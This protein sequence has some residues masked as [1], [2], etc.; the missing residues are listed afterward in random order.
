MVTTKRL[1]FHTLIVGLGLV[2]S[3]TISSSN[4]V[5]QGAPSYP[6][7]VASAGAKYL[8][9]QANKPFFINGE[10]AWSLITQP[11]REDATLFLDNRQQKGY[12]VFL[13]M[14]INHE[15]TQ[16]AP[17]NF[18]GNQPFTTAGNFS[19]PNEA[20]FQHAD[21]VINAAAARGQ[22]IMLA[23]IYIGW[24]CSSQGWCAEI[25]NQSLA[26]MR[27][28][29]QYVGNRYKN[30]P[31]IIWLIGGDA[32]AVAHGIGDKVSEF[33]AGL[34]ETDPNHIMTVHNGRGQSG[35]S[36]WPNASWLTLN[37][38]YTDNFTFPQA[39]TEYNR[40]PAKPAFLIESY[41]ERE[42]GSTS[43]SLRSQAYWVVLAGALGGHVFGN[44]PVTTFSFGLGACGD[45]NWK[46]YLDSDGATTVGHVGKL[47][48]S[49]AFHLLVPDLNHTVMTAGFQ[50]GTTYAN[51]ARTSDGSTVIA[52][53]PTSRAVT[54]D[55]TKVAGTTARTWWYN[56]RTG[57]STAGGDFPTTGTRNFTPPDGNDW[58]LVL[59][60]AALNL[61]APGTQ[62]TTPPA[63]AAP[64]NVRIVG[65]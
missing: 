9:D 29:G 45:P 47:F 49:R 14:L 3:L 22:V 21:W 62:G 38:V 53:I 54:F 13:V 20:Y 48:N 55:M 36:V 39:A 12:N 37:S 15:F 41:Y 32:D 56:P 34:A 42:H 64:T 24:S 10:S 5:A 50:S 17:R 23:P 60:N 7:K 16:N 58:V 28:W 33:V 35:S 51:A 44:C 40:S 19:T 1:L 46:S 25:R 52:Y 65:Q 31:N 6:V 4:L 26:T 43:L 18:Y 63:P 11:S 30:F 2:Y 61:S 59:D 57:T 8:A 27:A